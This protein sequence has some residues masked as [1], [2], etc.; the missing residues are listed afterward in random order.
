[1]GAATAVDVLGYPSPS[2]GEFGIGG[3]LVV[4]P[5]CLSPLGLLLFPAVCLEDVDDAFGHVAGDG[6]FEPDGRTEGAA[7]LGR[8]LLDGAG[9][10]K[11]HV[12][13]Q[14]D[15]GDEPFDD[16]PCDEGDA[17]RRGPR[18]AAEDLVLVGG[19]DGGEC[20]GEAAVG[21]AFHR[22]GERLAVVGFQAKREVVERAAL[23]RGRDAKR[24]ALEHGDVAGLGVDA[25]GRERRDGPCGRHQPLDR[26]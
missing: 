12:H 11:A 23:D 9:F 25:D 5:D 16:R 14:V 13:G 19:V 10:G 7:D 20:E 24:P 17:V 26:G 3:C 6:G 15:G 4:E 2:A 1:M 8:P 21:L 18:A 22:V